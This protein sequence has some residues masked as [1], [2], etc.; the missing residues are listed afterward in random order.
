MPL[1][2]EVMDK[3][4]IKTATVLWL[5]Q[6]QETLSERAFIKIGINSHTHTGRKLKACGIQK[7]SHLDCTMK[8]LLCLM[9]TIV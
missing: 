3:E 4:A 5:G 9:I 6:R 2:L 1:C 7:A 8:S